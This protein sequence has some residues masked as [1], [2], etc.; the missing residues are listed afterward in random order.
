MLLPNLL[1][2]VEDLCCGVFLS[3]ARFLFLIWVSGWV[4]RFLPAFCAPVVVFVGFVI[5]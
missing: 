3:S 1:A 4:F 5:G 2:I